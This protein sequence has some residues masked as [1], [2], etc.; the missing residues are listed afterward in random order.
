M[1]QFPR[2]S[3]KLCSN[4]LSSSLCLNSF[5]VACADSWEEETERSKDKL[6]LFFQGVGILS[7]TLQE[8]H[9]VAPVTHPILI[10]EFQIS[11]TLV[12]FQAILLK[13]DN[14]EPTGLWCKI[15]QTLKLEINQ[16]T[17]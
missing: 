9:V 1:K 7:G 12:V 14:K 15:R 13:A 10:L 2:S 11:Y 6:R 17:N 8:L 4:E 16:L 3:L 5:T